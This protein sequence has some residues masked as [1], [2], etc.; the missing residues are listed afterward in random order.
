MSDKEA[1]E[2][3]IVFADPDYDYDQD[4]SSDAKK[5]ED[6]DD[7]TDFRATRAV[8]RFAN[9]KPLPWTKEEANVIKQIYTEQSRVYLEKAANEEHFKEATDAHIL[10]ISTHG[11]VV[12]NDEEKEPLLKTALALTGYNTSIKQ[13]KDYGVMT[14]LKIASLDL[15][16]TELVVLSACETAIGESDNVIGVS[17][18]SR[19]F[20]IAG[21]KSTIA[22]LWEVEDKSTKEFFELFYHKIQTQ[23]NYAKAFKETQREMYYKLKG[24]KSHPLYWAGF[25]FFGSV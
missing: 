2:K 14:G 22:S 20:M 13:Q 5:S 7:S 6:N 25:A 12:Q 18:L 16:Q 8:T 19:A 24:T 23:T 10:H 4:V 1:Q 11:I 15:N 21:A 17:S 3:I 9:C